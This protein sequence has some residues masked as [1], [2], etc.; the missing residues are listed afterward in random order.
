VHLAVFHY[1]LLGG[2]VT[3]V[4]AEACGILLR[5]RV[6]ESITLVTGTEDK[7][8]EMVHRLRGAGGIDSSAVQSVVHPELGYAANIPGFNSDELSGRIKAVLTQNYCRKNTI[9]WIHNHHLGKNPALTRAVVEVL[10]ER[11]EQRCILQIHDFPE[12]GRYANLAYLNEHVSS[13]PYPILSNVQYVVLN[14]R[15]RRILLAAGIPE[16]ATSVLQNPV[17]SMPMKPAPNSG[18]NFRAALAAFHA[19]SGPPRT[20]QG[21]FDPAGRIL[22]YPVRCIRRKNVLEAALLTRLLEEQSEHSANLLITLPGVSEQERRYSQMVEEA[23]QRGVI[24]GIFG[25]GETLDTAGVTFS[26]LMTQSDLIISTSVQE[27]FGYA[28]FE[29]LASGTP[30]LA[31]Y[32]DVLE[33]TQ[34]LFHGF[35][36]HFYHGVRV[37]FS[38]PSLSDTR[39]YLRSRYQEQIDELR[40]HL[41]APVI[42]SLEG[43]I[44]EMLAA[45]D[46]D[47]SYL[48]P[49]MQYSFVTDLAD[50]DLRRRLVDANRTLVDHMASLI[51]SR[52]ETAGSAVTE[53]FGPTAFARAFQDVLDELNIRHS[54][55]EGSARVVSPR[56]V[57]ESSRPVQ[58]RV[59]LHFATLG[60]LRLLY[61][62]I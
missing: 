43:E 6:V 56:I 1:H 26:E 41:P 13:D 40:D 55:G 24:R 60:Y 3:A 2:G 22:V 54:G 47:F 16:A 45:E 17:K 19:K 62:G 50:R 31:R 18:G 59:L 21:S 11:P 7:V 39:S 8:Q 37:P 10:R 5:H 20:E 29:G 61:S 57:A 35:A 27:G 12:A 49:Q 32:L 36:A 33:G 58:Q 44:E 9:W 15:D 48:M 25:I 38:T 42:S 30:L 28:F 51:G 4:I 52:N 53:R 46:I 14:E 23:Y 34:S